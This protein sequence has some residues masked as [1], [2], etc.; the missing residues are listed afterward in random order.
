MVFSLV[1]F[2]SRARRSRSALRTGWPDAA[3]I[4]SSSEVM[5]KQRRF[6]AA[7][8][9]SL[10]PPGLGRIWWFAVSRSAPSVRLLR[11][12]QSRPMARVSASP[13]YRARPGPQT[14]N[15]AMARKNALAIHMAT[16][17]EITC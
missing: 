10:R 5:E 14:R 3:G 17:G 9:A 13:V 6:Q 15:R 12:R 8:P 7:G 4:R 11:G 2:R 1:I 16:N